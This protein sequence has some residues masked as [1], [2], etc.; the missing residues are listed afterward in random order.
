MILV[1]VLVG[2][3]VGGVCVWIRVCVGAGGAACV[4]AGVC[5][6]VRASRGGNIACW[7]CWYWC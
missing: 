6:G 5:V 7:W 3:G 1:H 4:G 2:C